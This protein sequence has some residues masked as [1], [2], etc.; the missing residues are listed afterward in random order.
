VGEALG[1][2][3]IPFMRVMQ[4]NMSGM[5]KGVSASCEKTDANAGVMRHTLHS[6]R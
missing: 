1:P 5:V 4:G 3:K 2:L 6:A